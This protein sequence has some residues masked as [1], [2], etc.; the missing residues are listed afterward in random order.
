MQALYGYCGTSKQG[1]HQSVR[2]EF[3]WQQKEELIVG[4]IMQLREVHPAMGLRTMYELSKPEGVGRDAF[5]AVGLYYGFRVKAFRNKAKTTFSSP[6]SRY[7]NLLVDKTLD[8]INQLWSSDLTYFKVGED[9]FYIT[10]I[11]DVYSRLITGYTVSDNMRAE[12]NVTALKMALKARNVR[13]YEHKLIH[14]SDR[15]GQYISD[16]YTNLLKG[17]KILISMCNEVYEN[18]HIERVNGTI[19]NQYLIHWKITSFSQLKTELKRAVQTYNC[20]RPHSSLKGMTPVAFE[21]YIKELK[22]TERPKLNIWTTSETKNHNP[23]QCI[24][25]F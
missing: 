24:I 10:F 25:Q 16:D 20:Q 17:Y 15:G 3:E 14:H 21:Q 6:Y 12:N 8:N 19:K 5:I 11:M 23:N 22:E 9:H 7:S 1:H 18:A 13:N 2:R 4:L